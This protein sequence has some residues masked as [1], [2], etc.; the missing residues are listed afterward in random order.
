M[1]P[2]WRPP[3][4]VLAVKR[5]TGNWHTAVRALVEERASGLRLS[6]LF[7]KAAGLYIFIYLL[8][9]TLLVSRG[10]SSVAAHG[11]FVSGP[12]DRRLWPSRLPGVKPQEHSP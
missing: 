6:P 1:A 7:F 3:S 11:R 2:R 12:E 10:R 8:S 5:S 4:A 9:C